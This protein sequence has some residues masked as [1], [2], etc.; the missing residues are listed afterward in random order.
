MPPGAAPA[1]V[2][3]VGVGAEDDSDV[4]VNDGKSEELDGTADSDA[5]MD[6]AANVVVGSVDG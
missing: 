3:K 2:D 5:M 6:G 4:I 1:S